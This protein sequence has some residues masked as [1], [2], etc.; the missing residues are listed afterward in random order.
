MKVTKNLELKNENK[1][2]DSINFNSFR[3]KIYKRSDKQNND[4]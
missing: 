2:N 3:K 1:N 4:K